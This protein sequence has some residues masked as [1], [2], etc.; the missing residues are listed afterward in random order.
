MI[1]NKFDLEPCLLTLSTGHGSMNEDYLDED[2]ALGY[3]PRVADHDAEL[4]HADAGDNEDEDMGGSD[5]EGGFHDSDG[6][7]EEND[8]DPD[9]VSS[10][11]FNPIAM[12]LKEIGGLARFRVSS[13]KP[14]NGVE[15]LVNDDTERYW[16][17]V[18]TI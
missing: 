1:A 14:G 11:P 3:I 15:E 9:A 4:A 10:V 12:G 7:A 17:Y 16:Q 6:E 8:L 5:V 2:E 18:L 13:Y